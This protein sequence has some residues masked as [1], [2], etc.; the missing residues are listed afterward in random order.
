MKKNYW[1]HKWKE[2]DKIW[3]VNTG[4]LGVHGISFDKKTV[5]ILP[6][7]Y[8]KLTQEQK[9]IFEEENCSWTYAYLGKE[10]LEIC[11]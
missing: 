9:K 3:W 6:K 4:E 7:D 11:E 2:T 1:F 5:F 8:E 10:E